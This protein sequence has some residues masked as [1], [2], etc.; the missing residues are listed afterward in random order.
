MGACADAL[1][2]FVGEVDGL[3]FGVVQSAAEDVIG[4]GLLGEASSKVYCLGS[5]LF[6]GLS[7]DGVELFE[8]WGGCVDCLLVDLV[9]K[10]LVTRTLETHSLF[11]CGKCAIGS[12]PFFVA[13]CNVLGSGVVKVFKVF[14]LLSSYYPNEC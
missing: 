5:G 11:V 8:G 6:L 3:E 10:Q 2:S 9:T 14:E 13:G 1:C 7:G 4:C 12:C